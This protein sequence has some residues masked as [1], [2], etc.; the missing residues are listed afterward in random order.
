ML[1]VLCGIAAADVGAGVVVALVVV[2]ALARFGSTTL[3]VLAASQSVLG[4]AVA[5][6]PA[7]AALGSAAA[8]LACV[9]TA[10]GRPVWVGGLLGG[11]AGLVTAGPSF[12]GGGADVAV[13]LGALVA[14]VA[15]GVASA[16]W[17]G[18]WAVRPVAPGLAAIALV[19]AVAR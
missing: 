19:L 16:R 15:A 13:R 3:P 7:A 12:S 1:A 2:G 14:G 4:P 10:G 18:R 6:G 5:A 9:A 17:G 11:V 8:G